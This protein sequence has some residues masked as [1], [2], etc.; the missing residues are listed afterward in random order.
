[1]TQQGALIKPPFPPLSSPEPQ[2]HPHT[3]ALSLSLSLFNLSLAMD[4]PIEQLHA[5]CAR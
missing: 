5:S 2:A 4:A 1:L 3:P